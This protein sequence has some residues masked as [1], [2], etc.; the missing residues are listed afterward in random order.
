V[1][2]SGS[3]KTTWAKQLI[4]HLFSLWPDMRVYVLD[5]KGDPRDFGSWRGI[6]EQDGPPRPLREPG[7]VQVWR[8]GFDDLRAYDEWFGGIRSARKPAIVLVDEV[9]S[10][11][12]KGGEAVPE[13]QKLMKQG[14]GL[15]I[16]PLT[17]SQEMAGFD[18]RAT[19]Q[20]THFVR[21]G[22]LGDYDRRRANTLMGRGPKE[23]EPAHRYGF[24]YQRLDRRPYTPVY[25]ESWRAFF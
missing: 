9:S 6:V 3:G 5:S 22:L 24:W 11:S 18:R 25:Y 10:I 4:Q 8:P 15:E 17:L 21:F 12:D 16:M 2:T 1:G 7:G 19:G 14:R 13:Y 23:E 20:A